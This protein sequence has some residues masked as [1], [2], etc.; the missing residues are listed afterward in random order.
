MFWYWEWGQWIDRSIPSSVVGAGNRHYLDELQFLASTKGGGH[1]G[2]RGGLSLSQATSPDGCYTL[3][4]K[5]VL[6]N[7]HS[8]LRENAT[9]EITPLLSIQEPDAWSGSAHGHHWS[10]DSG[11][12]FFLGQGVVHGAIDVALPLIYLVHSGEMVPARD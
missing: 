4:T 9:G 8:Y 7:H 11:A 1:P 6:Y 12:I 3:Y 5:S 2:E 10:A